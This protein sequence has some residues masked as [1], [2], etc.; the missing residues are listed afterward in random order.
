MTLPKLLSLSPHQASV[1]ATENCF[2]WCWGHFCFSQHQAGKAEVIGDAMSFPAASDTSTSSHLFIFLSNPKWSKH[3]R[4]QEQSHLLP[5]GMSEATFVYYLST[6]WPHK[7]EANYWKSQ[8]NKDGGKLGPQHHR[9]TSQLWSLC[10]MKPL[11]P[12]QLLPSPI[13]LSEPRLYP[14][15]LYRQHKF[16]LC[17]MTDS[18]GRIALCLADV[19]LSRSILIILENGDSL[20]RGWLT[21]EREHHSYYSLNVDIWDP[22]P[23]CPPPPPPISKQLRLQQLV[24]SWGL[25]LSN[26]LSVEGV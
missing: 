1:T 21:K 5:L 12:P 6:I 10:V 19:S 18:L 8:R 17:G 7:T 15:L 4:S 26:Q 16:K 25:Y 14:A 2:P 22:P 23:T 11:S 3:P 13:A 20:R 9:T 24:Y